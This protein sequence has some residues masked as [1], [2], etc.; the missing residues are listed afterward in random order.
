LVNLCLQWALVQNLVLR[1]LEFPL[2]ADIGITK[3]K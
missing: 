2:T 3:K 1:K